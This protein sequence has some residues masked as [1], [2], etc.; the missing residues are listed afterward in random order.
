MSQTAKVKK[1]KTKLLRSL[2]NA[3]L[4]DG[5]VLN[6]RIRSLAVDL[7]LTALR[8]SS[9]LRHRV[10]EQPKNYSLQRE[11]CNFLQKMFSSPQKRLS[12]WTGMGS[13]CSRLVTDMQTFVTCK[14]HRSYGHKNFNNRI[15]DLKSPCW[16]GARCTYRDVLAISNR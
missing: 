13:G 4:H 9:M 12:A 7:T 15:L 10:I 11:V 5:W 8:R 3:H 14:S 6:V 1:V 16:P 2:F